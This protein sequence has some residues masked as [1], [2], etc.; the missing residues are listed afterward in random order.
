MDK[1]KIKPKETKKKPQFFFNE[2]RKKSI[3]YELPGE[4]PKK[5]SKNPQFKC[6]I[7]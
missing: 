3:D 6:E 7:N 4:K 2:L 1:K 5:M